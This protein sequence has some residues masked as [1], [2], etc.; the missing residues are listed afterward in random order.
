LE[1]SVPYPFVRSLGDAERAVV[2]EAQPHSITSP[3]RLVANMDAVAYVVKRGIPGA[4]VECGVWR[5][6]SVLAMIRALQLNGV[7]DRD[8]YLFDTFEQMTE[9]T[10]VDTSRFDEPALRTWETARAQG[11]TPWDVYFRAELFSLDGTKELL[12]KTGYPAERLHFVVGR[13]EDTLP[14]S[15]PG[16][17]A[18][19][20]L[21]T[22]W[23]ESTRHE[24]LHLYPRLSSGG[25]LI[26][27][28][29]GHWDGCRRA[30]DE[31]FSG[32]APS[33]LLAR[34]DYAARL[35]IKP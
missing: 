3:E 11:K 14:G 1:P 27:D 34:I 19:L 29:Y 31:Y 2:E 7:N 8:L 23:Y 21:D 32:S 15:A 35:A 26:V 33:V 18:L 20:R 10:D 24:L 16:E 6:G 30:V 13:V 9:P 17:I 22:D 28:D 25:V 5:G 12:A 4:L